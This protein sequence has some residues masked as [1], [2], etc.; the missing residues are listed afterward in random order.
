MP[1]KRGPD[2]SLGVQLHG[3][4]KSSSS[5]VVINIT[6][7]T[8]ATAKTTKRETDSGVEIDV[9]IDDIVSE[10]L[11]ENGSSSN[12]ALSAFNSRQLI[13]RG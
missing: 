4:R 3:S 11:V 8:S 10:K 12:Q 1:L 6:N 5:G 2:G 7:N 13:K 9:L